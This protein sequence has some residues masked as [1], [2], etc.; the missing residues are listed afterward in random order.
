VSKA[1]PS[2]KAKATPKK[3]KAAGG[4]EGDES[5]SQKGVKGGKAKPKVKTEEGDDE[6]V[7]SVEGP[8]GV[9][10]RDDPVWE[11]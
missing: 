9:A 10:L 11:S 1:T 5:A 7:D 3:A 2:K 6:V 4:D 8:T